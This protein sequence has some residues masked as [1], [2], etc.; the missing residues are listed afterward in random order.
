MSTGKSDLVTLE[1]ELLHETDKA[2]LVSIDGEKTWL[3]KSM[4]EYE[5]GEVILPEWLA[6]ERGLFNVEAK[7][8]RI[9]ICLG[10]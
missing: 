4:V 3:P 2:M 9:N 6:I 1:G 7:R 8:V 5:D 10:S